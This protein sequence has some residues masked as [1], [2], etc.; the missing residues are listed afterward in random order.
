MASDHLVIIVLSS[1][2]MNP[3]EDQSQAGSITKLLLFADRVEEFTTCSA[4]FGLL[5]IC[6]IMHLIFLTMTK[7]GKLPLKAT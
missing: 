5:L 7:N 4:D 3:K 1:V 2:N 6:Y